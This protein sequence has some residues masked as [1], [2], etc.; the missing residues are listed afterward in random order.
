MVLLS[1]WLIKLIYT[2]GLR[3]CRRPPPSPINVS[4]QTH[5]LE[6]P[7][8]MCRHADGG[9]SS[10]RWRGFFWGFFAAKFS[11]LLWHICRSS[12]PA[13]LTQSRG[14]HTHTH[15]HTLSLEHI[16]L[17]LFS[18][19]A[20]VWIIGSSIVLPLFNSSFGATWSDVYVAGFQTAKCAP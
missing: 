18:H 15:T 10:V 3:F 7:E 14:A 19:A 12:V 9:R 8:G 17:A 20:C 4:W 5:L 2:R 13:A 16:Q 11:Q 6:P 1:P